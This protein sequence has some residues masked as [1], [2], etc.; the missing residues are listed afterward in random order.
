MKIYLVSVVIFILSYIGFTKI[1]QHQFFNIFSPVIISLREW[2]VDLKEFS[3]L[4]VNLDEVRKENTNL[5][6]L[7]SDMK[8]KLAQNTL[9]SINQ[10]EKNSLII[11]ENSKNL[12]GNKKIFVKKII[13][14][15]PF[16]SKL[17][18]DN[19]ENNK[20]KLNSLVL[21]NS[22]L[23]GL[24]NESNGGVVEVKLLSSSDL[25]INTQIVNSKQFKIKTVLNSESGDSLVI[26][27]ILATEEVDVGDIV[28]TSNS[29]EGILP[30]LI[31]GKIQRIEGIT[32]QTFRKAYIEK[33]YDLNLKNYVEIAVDE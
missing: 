7:L 24:A 32:S 10:R 28:I 4:V 5:K 2:S 1:L 16:A 25:N 21:L 33:N 13:Y 3:I 17:I 8:T 26:N 22:N 29:N 9:E 31:I 11:E 20:I 27:N 23:I 30:D 18:L 12:I 19:S 15:D 6:I 14:Y